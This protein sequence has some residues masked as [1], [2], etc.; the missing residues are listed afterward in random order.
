MFENETHL[1]EL[2]AFTR[3]NLAFIRVY[4]FKNELNQTNNNRLSV[5]FVHYVVQGIFHR[6]ILIID[7]QV[8]PI[9]HIVGLIVVNQS[10]TQYTVRAVFVQMFSKF[11]HFYFLNSLSIRFLICI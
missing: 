11:A 1:I 5:Y 9:D 7:E 3:A 10:G 2:N 8:L 4:L 6:Q